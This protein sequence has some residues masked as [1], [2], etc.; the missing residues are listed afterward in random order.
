MIYI[1]T[2]LVLD[3]DKPGIRIWT[4][5]V[6]MTWG[7]WLSL[8]LIKS[9]PDNVL[10]EY[11]GLPCVLSFAVHLDLG[12][13]PDTQGSSGM[14]SEPCPSKSYRVCGWVAHKIFVTFRDLGLGLWIGTWPRAFQ[15]YGYHHGIIFTGSLIRSADKEDENQG[16]DPDTCN[17]DEQ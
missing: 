3:R 9:V 16:G 4:Y 2:G 8:R 1:L 12:H 6:G 5:G 17:H 10:L 15:Y 13:L 7:Y 14:V 11:G